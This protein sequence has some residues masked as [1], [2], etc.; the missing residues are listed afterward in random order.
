M[1]QLELFR[2]VIEILRSL[3]I[4]QML[5]GSYASSFYGESR[6]T[7]DIDLVIDLPTEKIPALIRS[8]DPDRYYISESALREGRMANVIDTHSG[9]KVD[10]FLLSDDPDSRRQ[11]SRRRSG[12]IFD[13]RTDIATAEDVILSKLKWDAM[14]GG[15][16]QQRGDIRNILQIMS[17]KLDLQY[18]KNHAGPHRETLENLMANLNESN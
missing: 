10:L 13:V 5:V 12:E 14:L 17:G 3:E 4:E 16:Q 11:F 7:H 9:D 2:V 6:S 8:F 18:L 15:S 1:S